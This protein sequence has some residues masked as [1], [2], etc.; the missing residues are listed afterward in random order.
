MEGKDPPW[1]YAP[2][3]VGLGE[4]P[5]PPA[6]LDGLIGKH[7]A[8]TLAAEAVTFLIDPGFETDLAALRRRRFSWDYLTIPDAFP[9]VEG[10]VV[11]DLIEKVY[12][13]D[14]QCQASSWDRPGE[15]ARRHI[16]NRRGANPD[17][18]APRI[19]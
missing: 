5:S 19:F 2:W 13:E 12:I 9:G 8:Y 14:L 18:Y 4:I 6:N 15:I 17:T 1:K 11:K 3:T 7:P 10:S 16:L